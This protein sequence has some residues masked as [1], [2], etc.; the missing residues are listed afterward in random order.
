[1]TLPVEKADPVSAFQPQNISDMTNVGAFDNDRF[2]GQKR[3]IDEKI[4]HEQ[5]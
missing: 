4:A 1:M 2:A 5:P 3:F